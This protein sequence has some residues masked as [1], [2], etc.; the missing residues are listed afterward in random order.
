MRDLIVTGGGELARVIIETAIAGNWR[1]IGFVDP[2]MCPE[3]TERLDLPRLGGDEALRNY[4]KAMCNLAVG[5]IKVSDLRE[6]IVR[7][8]ALAEFERELIRSRTLTHR[9]RQDALARRG[10]GEALV[11]MARSYDVSHSTINRL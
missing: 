10:A 2:E 7:R 11:D 6:R 5:T 9:L 1:V 3:T 4:P 8:L